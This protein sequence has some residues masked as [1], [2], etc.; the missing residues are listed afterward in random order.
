M[1]EKKINTY[2]NIYKRNDDIHCEIQKKE[3]KE[4]ISSIRLE[5]R[6]DF[7]VGGIRFFR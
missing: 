1:D 3:E 5:A 6:F 4:K 7:A 2:I